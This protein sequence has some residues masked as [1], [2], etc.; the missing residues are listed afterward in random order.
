M[1]DLT[2]STSE[3]MN[4]LR[5]QSDAGGAQQNLERKVASGWVTA[6]R[7]FDR[8]CGEGDRKGGGAIEEEEEETEENK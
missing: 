1:G 6:R 8:V 3:R 2:A 7:S 4:Y 5:W